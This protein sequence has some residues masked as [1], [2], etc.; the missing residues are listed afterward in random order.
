MPKVD[1]SKIEDQPESGFVILPEGLYPVKLIA[2]DTDKTTR[3]GSEMWALTFVITGG[4]FEG[5]YIYDLMPFSERALPRVKLICSRL[6]VDVT[7]DGPIDVER[8]HILNTTCEVQVAHEEYEGK[9]RAKIPYDGYKEV[10]KPA[11]GNE[12][13]PF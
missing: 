3:D 5:R 9:T 1:F 12:R 8:G 2:I 10:S 6:G 11:S 7:K 13:M 4:P